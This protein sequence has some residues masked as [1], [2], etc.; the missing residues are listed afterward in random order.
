PFWTTHSID[1]RGGLLTCLTDSGEVLS[2]D[3]WLWSQWRAVWVFSRIFNQVDRNTR[4]LE[5]ARQIAEF[6]LEH[7]WDQSRDGWALVLDRNGH[8]IRGHESIY[9]DAFAVYGLV[10][11]YRATGDARFIDQAR[12]TADAAHRK[13]L[14]RPDEIPHFPYP[15]PR[16]A[17]PHGL[18]MIWSLKFAELAHASG[19]ERYAEIAR[20]FSD[21]LFT[22]SL[23]QDSQLIAEYVGTDG[24]PLAPPTGTVVVP[25]HALESLWFQIHVSHLIGHGQ[26][27]IRSIADLILRHLG[28]GWDD[29]HGGGISLAIDT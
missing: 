4:W 19:D 25:G 28:S 15:I 21:A 10:E 13:L 8:I 22:Q 2:T 9:V 3:K 24:A 5:L 14:G 27:R 16:D 23:Q 1:E 20:T 29:S 18:P 17:K 11:L 12:R 7:G 6:C 26:D